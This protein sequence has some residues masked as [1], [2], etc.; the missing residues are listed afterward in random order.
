MIPNRI[1]KLVPF[2]RVWREEIPSSTRNKKKALE[3]ANKAIEKKSFTK[4]E[5]V[6]LKLVFVLT[7]F[8]RRA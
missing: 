8:A 4:L 3:K 1:S 6:V 2:R 5:F 7:L